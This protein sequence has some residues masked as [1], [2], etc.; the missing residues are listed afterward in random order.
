MTRAW[1][2]AVV[3]GGGR[4]VGAAAAVRIAARGGRVVIMAR[5]RDQLEATAARIERAHGGSRAHA[6]VGD[7]GS[8]VDVQ[9]MAQAAERFLD[10]APDLLVNNAGIVRRALAHEMDESAWDAVMGTNLKGAWLCIRALLPGMLARGSGR[11]VNVA[12]ISATLGSPRMSAYCASKW[13]MVG[14][15]QSVAEETRDRGVQV[16]A[17][18]PG[19]IDTEMLVGSGFEARMTADEVA[20]TIEWLGLDAPATMTG[21]AVPMFG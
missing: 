5:T 21:S 9:R 15:T 13:G 14:L 17:V 12:S 16:M 1:P 6:V 18:L 19:S 3:T 10:G 4:G 7:V 2:S 11:I 8:A 20:R